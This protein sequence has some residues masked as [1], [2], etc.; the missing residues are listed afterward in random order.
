M[1]KVN[2]LT[3]Q[4]NKDLSQDSNLSKFMIS[5]DDSSDEED[6]VEPYD[7]TSELSKFNEDHQDKLSGDNNLSFIIHAA[8]I[9]LLYSKPVQHSY[10]KLKKDQLK[11]SY[12]LP[13]GDLVNAAVQNSLKHTD[14]WHNKQD[15]ARDSKAVEQETVELINSNPVGFYKSILKNELSE[16]FQSIIDKYNLNSGDFLGW[17]YQPELGSLRVTPQLP[18]KYEYDLSSSNSFAIDFFANLRLHN[19]LDKR[20][21]KY[22]EKIKEKFPE[23]VSKW[24]YSQ[25]EIIIDHKIIANTNTLR[26]EEVKFNDQTLSYPAIFNL[27]LISSDA[28]L[29]NQIFH[30]GT[31]NIPTNIVTLHY[32]LFGTEALRNP[33]ALIHN[34][35][36]LD[37]ISH[38]S[39][40]WEGAFDQ[41]IMP[42]SMEGAIMASR[43]VNSHYTKYMPHNYLYDKSYEMIYYKND[44]EA[45]HKQNKNNAK[46]LL[47]KELDF[48][49]L[50]LV[51]KLG[52]NLDEYLQ[53]NGDLKDSKVQEIF[54]LIQVSCQ[55]W[56]SINLLQQ[57]SI[58]ML[59]KYVKV[60]DKNIVYNHIINSSSNLEEALNEIK[61][62]ES[63]IMLLSVH[64]IKKD[65]SANN[66][67][68]GL[69]LKKESN[70]IKAWYVDP[71]GYP[72]SEDIYEL[73]QKQ[74]IDIISLFNKIDKP[75]VL[76]K[77]SF[78]KYS[79]TGYKY[80]AFK[81]IKLHGNWNVKVDIENSNLFDGEAILI[82]L[83]SALANSFEI[84]ECNNITPILSK[85]LSASL[86]KEFCQKAPLD[87]I[88][89][90]IKEILYP[91]LK[92][93][94]QYTSYQG[95][96]ISSLE[97]IFSNLVIGDC[98][99]FKN[100]PIDNDFNFC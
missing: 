37:L 47:E 5:G 83:L 17:Q 34:S 79:T 39:L 72:V 7:I 96:N 77:D 90:T 70:E 68:V 22:K 55:Q 15:W 93:D 74:N 48:T 53:E 10:Y 73:I 84:I 3:L 35:M 64:Q 40:T 44:P 76:T 14:N 33:S 99:N 86:K 49:K 67:L 58:F 6:T 59:D 54:Q 78:K 85:Q 24:K 87:H 12:D 36:M 16:Y 82:Y 11:D 50:W 29:L 56:F 61:V 63:A 20:A 52:N 89:E 28:L 62:V 23:Q 75:Q 42:M 41:K 69:Y 95:D 91:D 46:I 57:V 27:G 31:S 19:R 25:S 21:L 8:G 97:S 32:L 9:Q 2:Q 60:D 88:Q 94:I 81:D 1:S 18:H 65:F 51:M 98:N 71:T 4:I 30:K 80:I 100:C 92:Q 26:S 13:T 43:V 45:Y 66:F 38:A